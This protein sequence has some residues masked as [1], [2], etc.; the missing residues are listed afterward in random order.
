[1]NVY[2]YSGN[3]KVDKSDDGFSEGIK[4]CKIV[5]R[6]LK[7]FLDAVVSVPRDYYIYEIN[8]STIKS[9]PNTPTTVDK[10]GL[11]SH[12][13][14]VFAYE[15]YH[16]WS[17]RLFG[18]KEGWVINGEVGKYLKWFYNN[19]YD[20]NGKQKYPDLVLH[21][22][23]DNN[24][25][26]MIVC[27]I[28]RK[29]KVGQ[30][31]AEDLNKL[32]RFTCEQDNKH[33]W[34]FTPYYCG[35]YLIIYADNDTTQNMED[36]DSVSDIIIKNLIFKKKYLKYHFV[37]ISDE[38]KKILCIYSHWD[39]DGNYSLSY[40]SLYNILSSSNIFRKNVADGR[41]DIIR[42]EIVDADN[43]M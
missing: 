4:S 23:Q 19:K 30:G 7:K 6:H 34:S 17:C 33:G 24:D 39:S 43:M 29:D 13:E 8:E 40:Q 31:I 1:M 26:H 37:S 3:F 21:K 25:G 10:Y 2:N 11:F 32:C 20:D 41:G 5:K 14:R 36:K 18:N 27:E 28:K 16:R 15:L 42:T 9:N 35:I 38:A 22:G 12:V